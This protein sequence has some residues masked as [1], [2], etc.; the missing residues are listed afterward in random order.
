MRKQK[1]SR[2]H[3]PAPAALLRKAKQ[4]GQAGIGAEMEIYL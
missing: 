3:L 1:I 2:T 4:R